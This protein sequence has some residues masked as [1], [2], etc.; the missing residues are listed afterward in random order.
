MPA[1]ESGI[2]N[3]R[4]EYVRETTEGAPPTN[5]AWLFF[6]DV[7]TS[8]SVNP[9]APV[10][11]R[12][13]VGSVDI[14]NHF[15]GAEEH[16]LEVS[17]DLQQGL[18]SG[19]NPQDAAADGM[20]RGSNNQLP[21]TH[22]IVQ[23]D[24][25]DVTG[26]ASNGARLY[27]VNTGCKIGTVTLS[28]DPDGG[29]VEVTLSY[30]PKRTRIHRVDQP[31][32]G[33]DNLTVNSTD[34][35][36]D[37]AGITLED[38]GANLSETLTLSN[39][40][41]PTTTGSYSS[42]DAVRLDADITGNVTVEDSSGNVLMTIYGSDAYQGKDSD[43]GIPLLG[44]GSHATALGSSYE[45]I[46][47]D[48]IQRPS[49]TDLLDGVDINAI[50]LVVENN[51]ESQAVVNTLERVIKEGVR[52]VSLSASVFGA[53]PSPKVIREHLQRVENNIVWTLTNSTLTLNSAI[54]DDPGTIA[55]EAEQAI[56]LVDCSFSAKSLTVA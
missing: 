24:V 9:T 43:R 4:L 49:G 36:D 46:L 25:L 35:S 39:G 40:T 56:M 50:E 23:R 37:G 19:G 53:A 55:K 38:D 30:Q 29:A 52:N 3:Q 33:G 41:P 21:S 45:R 13:P 26:A 34:A 18:I 5:P 31:P 11:A 22:T 28:A 42:L 16:S 15:L 2:L 54:L 7:H 17:Y 1:A 32:S 48:T 6:S 12:R 10:S 47:G 51:L 8:I 14:D 20:T 27:T 44:T